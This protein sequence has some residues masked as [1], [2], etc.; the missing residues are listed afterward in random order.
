[1]LQLSQT[2]HG[3]ECDVSGRRRQSRAPHSILIAREL[4]I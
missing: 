3:S 4:Q 1:V 2:T